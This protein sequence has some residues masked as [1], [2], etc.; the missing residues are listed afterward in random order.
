MAGFSGIPIGTVGTT[1]GAT[2]FNPYINMRQIQI[3][4]ELAQQRQAAQNAQFAQEF[5]FR[6]QQAAANQK[7]SEADFG[8]RQQ[9]FEHQKAMNIENFVANQDE[10]KANQQNRVDSLALQ[11]KALAQKADEATAAKEADAAQNAKID[12]LNAVKAKANVLVPKAVANMRLQNPA[13]TTEQIRDALLAQA[14]QDAGGDESLVVQSSVNDW[15]KAE[16]AAE[17]ERA[18]QE[19]RDLERQRKIDE[20]ALIRA[21]REE[22]DAQR[23]ER[24]AAKQQVAEDRVRND[25]FKAKETALKNKWGEAVKRAYDVKAMADVQIPK[26][27]AKLA[28]AQS[29]KDYES[30][31]QYTNAMQAWANRRLDAINTLKQASDEHAAAESEVYGAAG[32]PTSDTELA[33]AT[34]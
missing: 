24:D 26:L 1:P 7:A 33:S 20:A 23:R 19:D 5:A 22:F 31:A 8:L 16:K 32:A 15:Y 25:K 13:L 21:Q 2:Q 14:P 18:A 12:N 29:R 9:E 4:A 27:Q 17:K 3:E 34:R 6:G 30:V 28:E 11:D 10:R